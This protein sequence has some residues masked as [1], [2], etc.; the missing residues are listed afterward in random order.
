MMVGDTR[1]DG[2]TCD[3]PLTAPG[4]HISPRSCGRIAKAVW[5]EKLAP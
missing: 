1:R 5:K 2:L 4:A 3:I